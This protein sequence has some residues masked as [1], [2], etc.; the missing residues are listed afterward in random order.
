MQLPVCLAWRFSLKPRSLLV[1]KTQHCI[2][3]LWPCMLSSR[4]VCLHPQSRRFINFKRNSLPDAA[5]VESDAAGFG[6][7]VIRVIMTPMVASV[8]FLQVPTF[9]IS[10]HTARDLNNMRM[11]I[12][13]NVH[14]LLLANIIRVFMAKANHTFIHFTVFSRDKSALLRFVDLPCG[15]TELLGVFVLCEV[16]L[17]QWQLVCW[18]WKALDHAR[19][20]PH[21][22]LPL[23]GTKSHRN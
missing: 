7:A 11:I 8:D 20:T 22:M 9:K 5:C 19:K 18:I 23:A 17:L 13:I 2:P 14:H 10:T 16:L 4:Q 12:P 3:S 1:R 15:E 21:S 6:A